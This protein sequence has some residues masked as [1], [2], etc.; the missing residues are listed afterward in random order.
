MPSGEGDRE[1]K[2]LFPEIPIWIAILAIIVGCSVTGIMVG[3]KA[4]MW[5]NQYNE[6][7]TKCCW[8]LEELQKCKDG[9]KDGK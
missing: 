1:M 5:R 6:A 9:V 7:Q 3:K 8:L 4:D 2:K